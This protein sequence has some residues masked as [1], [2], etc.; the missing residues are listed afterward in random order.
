[1]TTADDT[2]L[3]LHEVAG[4]AFLPAAEIRRLVATDAIPHTRPDRRYLPKFRRKA[5]L[6]WL[7][8]RRAAHAQPRAEHPRG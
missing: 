3:T 2:L 5:V 4:L 8:E 7:A 1:M 6:T